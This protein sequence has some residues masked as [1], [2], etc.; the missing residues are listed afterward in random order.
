[1]NPKSS[2]CTH[3]AVTGR[4]GAWSAVPLIGDSN[5]P[6]LFS[7]GQGASTSGSLPVRSGTSPVECCL[8]LVLAHV[9]DP[10]RCY[11][12]VHDGGPMGSPSPPVLSATPSTS[13]AS[14]SRRPS[15]N[16]NATRCPARRQAR[17]TNTHRGGLNFGLAVLK[18]HRE[19]SGVPDTGH[20]DLAAG[21]RELVRAVSRHDVAVNGHL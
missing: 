2:Y 17:H 7:L 19:F 3:P 1:M 5:R 18:G 9:A 13:P 4:P 16:Q 20:G 11:P 12:L 6:H 15:G 10:C 8:P 21:R 14:R